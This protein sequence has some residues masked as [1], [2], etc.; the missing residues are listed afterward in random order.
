MGTALT[1]IGFAIL[2]AFGYQVYVHDQ[3][4]RAGLR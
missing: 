3:N 4:V 2:A 1:I